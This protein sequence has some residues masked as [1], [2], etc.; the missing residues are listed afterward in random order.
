DAAHPAIVLEIGHRSLGPGLRT[1]WPPDDRGVDDV[2]AIAEDV[3]LD[4]EILVQ[5]HPGG[6]P[7]AIDFRTD[8]LEGD[9]VGGQFLQSAVAAH[10][11]S[12]PFGRCRPLRG[13]IR[14][15]RLFTR[16][17]LVPLA[18]EKSTTEGSICSSAEEAAREQAIAQAVDPASTDSLQGLA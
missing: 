12:A 16:C 13:C 5:R 17:S 9:P 8:A 11:W 14:V 1:S 18:P 15:E 6:K 4:D 2:V 7:A 3:C 10:R